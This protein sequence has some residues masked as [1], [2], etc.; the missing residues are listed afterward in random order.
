METHTVAFEIEDR[1]H[2]F[3]DTEVFVH[4]NF[5]FGGALF[6][7]LE[8]ARTSGLV[9][10]Y[11]TSVTDRETEAKIAE[12]VNDAATAQRK[13]QKEAR[14]LRNLSEPAFT[15]LFEE[16][17]TDELTK[18]LLSQYEQFKKRVNVE[19]VPNADDALD[20]VLDRYFQRKPPF[21]EGKK[22]HEFP[23]AFA[24]TAL[25]SWCR[26][27]EIEEMHVVSS[28]PDMQSAC[29][30]VG[31]FVHVASLEKMLELITEKETGLLQLGEQVLAR[32]AEQI[33][34][35]IA[36]QFPM[37]G[38]FLA[39]Q[40]GDIVEVEADHVEI[41]E[42]SLVDVVDDEMTFRITVEVSFRAHVVADDYS[43]AVYERGYPV[44]FLHQIDADLERT[45]TIPAEIKIQFERDN[46]EA[47]E[48]RNVNVDTTNDVGIDLELYDYD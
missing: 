44:V 22:K 12:A 8:R 9:D 14:I 34:Q 27:E 28:D 48:L 17:D 5:D 40:E 37:L 1:L 46:P 10:L 7:R 31:L 32:N 42:S 39:D 18:Q 36:K 38:F 21:G 41:E 23:D 20:Q 35:E 33:T 24:I 4:K 25:E 19:V 29:Y 47:S 11:V 45:V 30:E 26:D 3:L 13:F 15:G 43:T 2:V 6:Q 16:F